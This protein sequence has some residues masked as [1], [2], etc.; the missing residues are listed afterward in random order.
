MIGTLVRRCGNWVTLKLF[1]LLAAVFI[2]IIPFTISPM[3][4]YALGIFGGPLVEGFFNDWLGL[5]AGFYFAAVLGLAAVILAQL[6]CE[7]PMR[8]NRRSITRH[9]FIF[10]YAFKKEEILFG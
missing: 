2:F 4:L 7:E 1:Y 5:R 6:I 9:D 10:V 3:A 8:K